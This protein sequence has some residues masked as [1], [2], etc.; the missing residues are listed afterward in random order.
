MGDGAVGVAV[1]EPGADGEGDLADEAG[2][3]VD[4]GELG[5]E[6]GEA[7]GEGI[8]GGEEEGGSGEG[9]RGVGGGH[10]GPMLLERT[11]SLIPNIP[12]QQMQNGDF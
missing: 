9:D 5:A 1:F 12:S 4:V 10:H 6:E 2:A 3:G 11:D 7:E 8:G